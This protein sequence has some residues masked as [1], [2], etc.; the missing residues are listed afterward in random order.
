M[1]LKKISF[2]IPALNEAK[3]IAATIS[4][5]KAYDGSKEIIVSDGGS[6]DGTQGIARGTGALVV[7]HK[8][9]ERQTIAA[10]RNAGAKIASGDYFVFIDADVS[11]PDINSFFARALAHFEK[12]KKLVA[13]TVSYR[14]L[15][16]NATLAD[17]FVFGMLSFSFFLFNNILHVGVAG[18]E[19][20]MIKREAFWKVGGFNERL[21]AAE[22]GDM[23]S[24]LSKIG[25][26]Y[27][28]PYICIYHSGRR[29]HAVGWPRLIYQ[30]MRNY[31]TVQFFKRSWSKEWDEVR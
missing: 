4:G 26:T 27:C 7:E 28:D 11:I 19:F 14:I 21:V 25:R 29:E 2:I 12:R 16:E 22:D 18:G 5:L 17:R 1:P 15:P 13:L 23:F 10:G 20:Q 24:R 8:S 30:W 9:L 3:I 31:L 6:R